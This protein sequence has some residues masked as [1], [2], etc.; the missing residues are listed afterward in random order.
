MPT[1]RLLQVASHLELGASHFLLTLSC[2]PAEPPLPSWQAGQF[3]MIVTG[4]P[5]TDPLLRRPFSIF[6]VPGPEAGGPREAAFFYKA[7]GRGT[8]LLSS[9]RPGDRIRCLLPLGNGFSRDRRDG[10]RLLLVAGGIGSASVHPLAIQELR[11]GG[12]P[13]MLYGCRTA[14][15]RAGIR[16]TEEGG[17]EVRVATDDGSAGKRGYVSEL[18]DDVLRE[19]GPSAPDRWVVCACGPTPMMRAT[20]EVARRHGVVCHLSLESPMACGFG[21]C[22]GCVVGIR[23]APDGP[24]RYQR[25][26]VDGPVFDAAS[27]CW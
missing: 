3:A 2:P 7:A 11:Q 27:V 18:L 20:A 16:P 19:T 26:C 22:V 9:A 8:R 4:Q 13:L 21:V 10:R 24:L 17:V 23:S 1:D 15:E 12:S 5:G 6:S 25:I 14:A